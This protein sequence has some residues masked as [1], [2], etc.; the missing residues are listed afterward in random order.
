MTIK[1]RYADK[2]NRFLEQAQAQGIP[3][4]EEQAKRLAR[5][6]SRARVTSLVKIAQERYAE[7]LKVDAV[8][9][10]VQPW[11]PLELVCLY[12]LCEDF[13]VEP[14][15]VKEHNSFVNTENEKLT[16]EHGWS[17][18]LN[19][20]LLE[21]KQDNPFKFFFYLPEHTWRFILK[22]QGSELE[23]SAREL[24]RT[25]TP[26]FLATLDDFRQALA[27]VIQELELGKVLSPEVCQDLI[28]V[29]QGKLGVFGRGF[30]TAE[31][32][33]DF[34]QVLGTQLQ[35]KLSQ[36]LSEEISETD[37][38]KLVGDFCTC[39]QIPFPNLLYK[40]IFTRVAS[41]F[42][43]P[44]LPNDAFIVDR[45]VDELFRYMNE[46]SEHLALGYAAVAGGAYYSLAK[47][48]QNNQLVFQYVGDDEAVEPGKFSSKWFTPYWFEQRVVTAWAALRSRSLYQE[49]NG[50]KPTTPKRKLQIKVIDEAQRLRAE[51]VE[52]K[53]PKIL[54]VFWD[55]RYEYF[56]KKE[57]CNYHFQAYYYSYDQYLNTSPKFIVN[58]DGFRFSSS[59]AEREKF[60]MLVTR[61]EDTLDVEWRMDVFGPHR[62]N[63]RWLQALGNTIEPMSH[64]QSITKALRKLRIKASEVALD[65]DCLAL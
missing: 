25:P 27:K 59:K 37:L 4:T 28:Q 24:L 42:P 7:A 47:L 31:V 41:E 53:F 21:I 15:L 14:S 3:L 50:E 55:R 1:N 23:L 63:A 40:Q 16:P 61:V 5:E 38:A 46:L 35:Q 43:Q 34:A 32:S 54:E 36:R 2:I 17:R 13:F 57:V 48:Y 58:F 56:L 6:N 51:D 30:S 19:S 33:A 12:Q 18:Y 65:N 64:R 60:L 45:Y 49:L 44:P 52:K 62:D 26:T 22:R 11:T 20:S 9:P 10:A 39:L 29:K 8:K